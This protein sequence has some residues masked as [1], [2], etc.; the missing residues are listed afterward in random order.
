MSQRIRVVMI[1][2]D[3]PPYVT[4]INGSVR[5][6]RKIVGGPI[7]VVTVVD[8]AIVCN[9]EGRLMGLPQ[10][11]TCGKFAGDIFIAKT[12]GEEFA[13]MSRAEAKEILHMV[14][15][16]DWP[17]GSAVVMDEAAWL[18]GTRKG[19]TQHDAE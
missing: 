17:N 11:Q 13:K 1:P 12:N 2:A 18:A 16:S 7:E 3:R 6:I 9:E 19:G 5:N 8:R 10:N 15:K 4:N 14:K